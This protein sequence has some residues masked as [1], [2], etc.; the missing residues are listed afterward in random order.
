M[1][2]RSG[3]KVYML[4][5]GGTIGMAGSPLKPLPPAAFAKLVASQPGFT[6]ST[7]TV[8]LHDDEPSV[9][10][11]TLK[12]FEDP[13]DSSS[14]T[15][16][17]WIIIAKDLLKN[18]NGYDGLVVLHGTD[19]LAFTASALSFLMNGLDKP[20]VVTGSQ[21]PLQ[22]TRNDALR[23]MIS[24]IVVAATTKVPESTL[25]FDSKLMRGNR[26]AKV[27]ASFFS[28]FDSPNFESLGKLGIDININNS[29]VLSPPPITD[30]LS[31]ENNRKVLSK[32]LTRWNVAYSDFSVISLI[33]FPGIQASM[34]K[35]MLEDTS[36][37]VKGI[38]IMAFGAGNAPANKDLLAYLKVAHKMGL[39]LVDITQVLMG[40]VDLDAYQSASG[41]KE[42]GAVSGY[43]MTPEAALTK[44]IW[45]IGRGLSQKEIEN[46]LTVDLHGEVSREIVDIVDSIWIRLKNKRIAYR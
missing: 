19:T 20:I 16:E 24:A 14:M 26:S 18:Y 42:A 40:S 29:L 11:Y 35:A 3:K 21:I 9:I 28:A 23:N 17:D 43:D 27:N 25:L 46:E 8:Q 45:L 30:S 31:V 34:V 1:A 6:E 13:L 10:D 15:P 7:L 38:V 5:T 22:Q 37:Q 33:L 44:L 4:Y 12:S 36:P 39:V 32:A 2:K 41:L